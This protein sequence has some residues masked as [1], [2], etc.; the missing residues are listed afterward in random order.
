MFTRTNFPQQI[1]NL[2]LHYQ[3]SLIIT[4][5]VV[6]GCVEWIWILASTVKTA[7]GSFLTAFEIRKWFPCKSN[8]LEA[9]T[10]V[11]SCLS[12]FIVPC[13]AKCISLHTFTAWYLK[14]PFYSANGCEQ[15]IP[16]SQWRISPI[17]DDGAVWGQVEK[18]FAFEDTIWGTHYC[19]SHPIV[20]LLNTADC[21][22]KGWSL[23]RYDVELAGSAL[24]P[25]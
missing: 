3:V 15:T 22:L 23:C 4:R 6:V 20:S 12:P 21:I 24:S 17:R 9:K 19:T 25:P 10:Y 14:I 5:W 8:S 18:Q 2:W 16:P 7:F 11:F 1:Y 13:G